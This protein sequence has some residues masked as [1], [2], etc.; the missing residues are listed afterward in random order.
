MRDDSTLR[1]KV[2]DPSHSFIVQAPAG[3]GK[4]ELLIQRYLRLLATVEEPEQ[5][6]A[7]TFTRK[8][9]AEMRS[10]VMTAFGKSAEDRVD[11]APHYERT[12]ELARGAL[13]ADRRHGWELAEH[14]ERLRIETL[15]ALNASLAQ[16]LP[17]LSGGIA[18]A[19]VIEDA[20]SLYREAAMHTVTSV[21][22][23]R[24]GARHVRRVLRAVDYRVDRLERMIADLLAKREQ[25]LEVI[26]DL[27]WIQDE[28]RVR[29]KLEALGGAKLSTLT[30]LLSTT[31]RDS[32]LRLVRFAG[33]RIKPGSLRAQLEAAD[34][35][36]LS[37]G[38]AIAALL[39]TKAGDWRKRWTQ[40]E[41]FGP[42]AAKELGDL[43]ELV[44]VLQGRSGARD[45]L[46]AVLALPHLTLT[47]EDVAMLESV[48]ALLLHATAELRVQFSAR[49]RVD[50]AELALGAQQALG[51][52]DRPSDLL[53]A[54]DRRI[55][56]ILV[57]EF[58]DTSKSQMQLLE[59]LTAGWQP[60]D[61]RTLFLVGDPMQSIYRFRSA[62]MSLFLRA[63]QFGVGVV[64]CQSVVLGENFR[65][66]S[67]L[68]D[69]VNRTFGRIFPA[70]DDVET[71]SA[72][73]HGSYTRRG[74]VA[75]G[76]V[77]YHIL[78]TA[79]LGDEIDRIIEIVRH[80]RTV[81]PAQS[82]GVLVQSRS[83]L[84]GLKRR[85]Q[86]YGLLVRAVEID[87]L[88]DEPFVQDLLGLCRALT[89]LADRSAWLAVLRA[90]WCGLTWSD[91]ERL[92]RD[93]RDTTVW[94]L[95]HNK[96]RL[97]SLS[98]DGRERLEYV[99]Q[100]LR[101]AFAL[102]GS[103]RFVAWVERTWRALGGPRVA[104]VPIAD[105][106]LNQFFSVLAAA[107]DG[108]DVADSAEL[109]SHFESP[110]RQADETA[111]ATIEIMTI[112][113]AK[114]L[115]FDTVIISG[116][117]RTTRR[118]DKQL[119]HW[120]DV[121]APDGRDESIVVPLLP[122][123][124]PLFDYVRRVEA[125]RLEAE[126]AR[127]LYVATTRARDRL[128]LIA[129]IDAEKPAAGSLLSH[130][131][132]DV[133]PPAVVGGATALRTPEYV[134]PILRRLASVPSTAR[135]ELPQVS[136]LSDTIEYEWVGAAAA[137][138]GIVVHRYLQIIADTGLDAWSAE[139]VRASHSAVRSELELLGVDAGAIDRAQA[140]VLAALEQVLADPTGRWILGP[141][142]E[143]RSELTL[144]R[145]IDNEI[146][147]LR[148]DRTFVDDGVR[149]I[150]DYKSGGHEGG[151]VEA[152]L[153]SEIER[154]RPQLD[155]Y[156][157]AVSTLDPRPVRIG[158]YFPLMQAF[159]D[160]Q[161]AL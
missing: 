65:A 95:M 133:T 3:S 63:R 101:A 68:I 10:R 78:P 82:I 143:A 37:Q 113:R 31:E 89:H 19:Q 105:E 115:E 100:Q 47:A 28:Q 34:G 124:S 155:E 114:G 148:L 61:G 21:S 106:Q 67:A 146:V 38:R 93:D 9:A 99:R 48:R 76:G 1:A 137:P 103:E 55:Q 74:E 14:P 121:T 30:Q 90:P 51:R 40:R 6:V 129:G 87:A 139:R 126:R 97:S 2:L 88:H 54:I 36:E 57:D 83:H 108:E 116:L 84:I 140:R 25:W 49:Q 24:A 92:T 35:D 70:R 136:P 134:A 161:P 64:K 142:A 119:I 149:W 152:F 147:Y 79:E 77:N 159:H 144:S 73:F 138:I 85:L 154:Y 130:L 86:G 60:D 45:A 111:E 107:S 53:L 145:V 23:A 120:H 117:N 29:A 96:Q 123:S 110:Q 56:H 12:L 52:V 8:A 20:T 46:S 158:L 50:F 42:D 58:Q 109:E 132:P 43:Q 27:S 4:T 81:S 104:H 69:W 122:K 33:T 118:D 66:S 41:G 125:Q 135:V 17:L 151:D 59:L 75:R 80:E 11:V 13:A 22:L 128:H 91:L 16:R 7:I 94:E 141:R 32:L 102:R 157:R 156:A 131:W 127:L 71:G 98:P 44:A 18:G 26:G 112:H 5:V 62:D 160:W 39:L 150:V 15:D 153:Q 72:Q